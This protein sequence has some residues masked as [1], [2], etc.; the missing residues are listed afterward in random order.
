MRFG[1]KGKKWDI[2]RFGCSDCH[3]P[4]TMDLRVTRPSFYKALQAKGV[5]DSNPTKNDMRSYVCG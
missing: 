2:P 4:K 3:D 5:E 1:L